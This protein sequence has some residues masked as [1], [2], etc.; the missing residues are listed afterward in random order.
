DMK[1]GQ[2]NESVITSTQTFLMK[3]AMAIAALLTGW[4]LDLFGYQP[5]QIQSDYTKNGLRFVMIALPIISIIISYIIYIF[6][7]NLKV[8]YLKDIVAVLNLRNK[9]RIK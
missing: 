9:K 3:V 5:G 2:R 7:Y 6:S 1:F 4:S 8:Y